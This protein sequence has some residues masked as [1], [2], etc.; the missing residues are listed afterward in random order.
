[1]ISW[2]E[3]K[4]EGYDTYQTCHS[5]NSFCRLTQTYFIV[6]ECLNGK[7]PDHS[8]KIKEGRNEHKF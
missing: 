2:I 3:D 4:Q 7:I 5:G 8:V 6:V 1:M